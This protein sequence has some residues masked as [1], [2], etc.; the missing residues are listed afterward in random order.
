MSGCARED[1]LDGRSGVAGGQGQELGGEG[2]DLS[3]DR[4]GIQVG[5]GVGEDRFV[6][7]A[8]RVVSLGTPVRRGRRVVLLGDFRAVADLGDEFL[9]G[10]E[11]VRHL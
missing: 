10:Q 1:W 11:V 2:L 6:L 3:L 4:G 8:N 5:V 7:D 9:L